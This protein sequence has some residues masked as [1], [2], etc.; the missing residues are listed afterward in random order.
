MTVA[1]TRTREQLANLALRKLGV[2]AFNETPTAED[3]SLAYEAIDLRIK[4]MH[5]LGT[6]WRKVSPVASTFIITANTATAAH[7]LTDLLYPVSMQVT[8]NSE[9]YPIR[10]IGPQEYNEISD[11]AQS[12]D[13]EVAVQSAANFIF[14][15]VPTTNTTA[16]IV[17]EKIG[18]DTAAGVQPDVEVS[19]LRWMKDI[20]TYDLMDNFA[21]PPQKEQRFMME[22]D[23]AEKRIRALN[24]QRVGNSPVAVDDFTGSG[25]YE[26][27]YGM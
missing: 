10:I 9:D 3:A 27:D 13:P 19:M 11:K 18:D 23:L 24:S 4:E 22:A 20:I 7:G 21:I 2:I 15:P 6:F 1:F 12:G 14:W 26:T 17:Y 8:I 25:S 5:R 16:K